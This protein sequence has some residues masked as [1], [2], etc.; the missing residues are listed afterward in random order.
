MMKYYNMCSKILSKKDFEVLVKELTSEITK[1]FS[2]E[3]LLDE[4]IEILEVNIKII[5]IIAISNFLELEV[6][7]K[8]EKIRA[9]IIADNEHMML[10]N[11]KKIEAMYQKYI[12]KIQE[13][14][15]EGTL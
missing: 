14:F 5:L 8:E 7:E 12:D 3:I 4:Y 9:K 6:L 2:D 10:D 11:T 15:K 13:N 1:K